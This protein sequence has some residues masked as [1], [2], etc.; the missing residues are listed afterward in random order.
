VRR[1]T[2]VEYVRRESRNRLKKSQTNHL[3]GAADETNRILITDE[4]NTERKAIA[5]RDRPPPRPLRRHRA[6]IAQASA[7]IHGGCYLGRTPAAPR[8]E[9]TPGSANGG[10]RSSKA[11]LPPRGPR[12][13]P[14]L[15]RGSRGEEGWR[16]GATHRSAG[17]QRHRGARSPPVS[18]LAAGRRGNRSRSER[19]RASG[20]PRLAG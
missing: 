12:R 14:A 2:G 18:G 13:G 15:R 5:A 10:D 20:R 6:E 3:N 8:R 17:S 19:A 7:R 11:A 16:D 9:G 1:V 4:K